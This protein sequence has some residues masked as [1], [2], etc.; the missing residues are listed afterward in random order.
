[1]LTSARRGVD[2]A[3]SAGVSKP[4]VLLHLSHGWNYTLQAVFYDALL[5]TGVFKI[6]DWDASGI[7]LYPYNG[8]NSTYTNARRSLTTLA[9][10]YSKPLHV[11]ETNYPVVCTKNNN[12]SDRQALGLSPEAQI[13]WI[14]RVETIVKGLPHG[15]GRGVWVWEPGF[16]YEPKLGSSCDDLLLFDVDN[17][18]PAAPVG[19]SRRSVD[20]Y[21][22]K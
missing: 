14:K 16:L 11:A 17:S 4:E 12:T 9:R 15:L 19:Y 3:V 20:M 18:N 7:S 8:D 21:L 1:V 5:G 2:D 22:E 13:S 10:K 6:S